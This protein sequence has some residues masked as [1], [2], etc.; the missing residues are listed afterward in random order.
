MN[1][2]KLLTYSLVVLLFSLSIFILAAAANLGQKTGDDP[3]FCNSCH[4][5]NLEAFTWQESTHRNIACNNCHPRHSILGMFL[6]E[7]SKD[8]TVITT[9]NFV[10]NALCLKCHSTGRLVTPPEGLNISHSVHLT[11]GIDCVDCHK[12]IAHA[13]VRLKYVEKANGFTKE[14]AKK[15]YVFGNRVPMSTCLKCHNGTKAPNNC[16]TCHKD[17]QMPIS[18]DVPDWKTNHGNPALFD[19]K[20]CNFCHQFDVEKQQTAKIRNGNYQ[21]LQRY[22]RGMN[23]CNDCHKQ[24][25]DKHTA[26]FSVTH[27]K[28]AKANKEFCLVCHNWEVQNNTNKPPSLI[29]C[30]KCHV[31]SV[32][33]NKWM[34]THKDEFK[35]DKK[36]TAMSCFKCHDQ[37]SCTRC[38]SA[39]GVNLVNRKLY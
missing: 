32:H 7:R 33:P 29:L 21:S 1:S 3:S 22:A 20:N 10:E 13:Q 31:P 8:R 17:K 37:I 15:M 5:M 24:R 36:T 35:P 34:N 19:L 27:N 18:H 9:T 39:K 16:N 26:I 23:F 25:P 28:N 12:S 14:D 4:Q 11:K 6:G 38:H 2:N 30:N